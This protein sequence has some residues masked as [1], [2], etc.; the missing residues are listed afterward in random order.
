L[1]HRLVDCA[2]V[3]PRLDQCHLVYPCKYILSSGPYNRLR[4]EKLLAMY[5]TDHR[6]KDRIMLVDE[7]L[8]GWFVQD[9]LARIPPRLSLEH[10]LLEDGYAAGPLMKQENK[11]GKLYHSN[12]LIKHEISPKSLADILVDK[13]EH[14]KTPAFCYCHYNMPKGGVIPEDVVECTYRDCKLKYFHK[15]CVKEL[16]F[17]KVSR[18][19]C[20][21]CEARMQ[22]LANRFLGGF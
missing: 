3:D 17:E 18:W 2:C 15:S 19:L 13:F 5:Q 4:G 20:T 14:T 10:S 21:D 16:G 6:F 12:N 8:M 11:F 22:S 9:P 7:E 1:T